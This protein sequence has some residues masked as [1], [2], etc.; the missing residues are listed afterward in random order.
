MSILRKMRKNVTERTFLF[1]AEMY[2][3]PLG[4]LVI[5]H[6]I[7]SLW[8]NEPLN[9]ESIKILWASLKKHPKLVDFWIDVPS[10]IQKALALFGIDKIQYGRFA[11]VQGEL[12][13][14]FAPYIDG[15]VLPLREDGYVP[16]TLIKG[17][18]YPVE[19]KVEKDE[20]LETEERA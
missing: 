8:D 18:I 3:N 9:I 6:Y 15:K 5:T 1:D 7:I 10:F 2:N 4:S 14:L 12:N 19:E 16:N 11:M 20:R 17:K 13:V